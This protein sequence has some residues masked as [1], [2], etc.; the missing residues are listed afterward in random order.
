MTDQTIPTYQPNA[1]DKILASLSIHDY[2]SLFY[3][4][5]GEKMVSVELFSDKAIEKKLVEPDGSYTKLTKRGVEVAAAVVEYVVRLLPAEEIR[6]LIEQARTD[7]PYPGRNT[8]FQ[9]MRMNDRAGYITDFGRAVAAAAQIIEAGFTLADVTPTPATDP[10]IAALQAK[11]DQQ[12]AEM[13][14]LKQLLETAEKLA[15]DKTREK[16]KADEQITALEKDVATLTEQRDTARTLAETYQREK[17]KA[18]ADAQKW[19][20]EH[21]KVTAAHNEA[22]ELLES[23]T[24]QHPDGHLVIRDAT[25][26]HLDRFT[27]EGRTILNISF[28][29]DDDMILVVGPKPTAPVQPERSTARTETPTQ[30]RRPVPPPVQQPPAPRPPAPVM[31]T[32]IQPSAIVPVMERP[33]EDTR[34]V[35]TF[36]EMVE[37]RTSGQ[38]DA[39]QFTRFANALAGYNASKKA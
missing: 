36:M 38:I 16:R 12:A 33:A 7:K 31:P 29:R 5:I 4:H 15:I 9:E 32:A 24:A 10:V 6:L 19:Q 30:P 28:N 21:A 17:E 2:P 34:R 37:A 11:I 14:T 25:A 20:R 13:M 18:I 35:P 3:L 39:A 8:Q 22:N 1:E 23:F 27:G 26:Q